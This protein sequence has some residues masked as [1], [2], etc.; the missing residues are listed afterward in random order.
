MSLNKSTILERCTLM[1]SMSIGQRRKS[2]S[3]GNAMTALEGIPV[4]KDTENAL[5]SWADGTKT[6]KDGYLKM[7]VKYNLI[8]NL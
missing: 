7:L 1:D 6:F 2:L 4:S 5:L 8:D 3:F